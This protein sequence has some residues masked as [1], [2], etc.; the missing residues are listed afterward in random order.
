MLESY[1]VTGGGTFFSALVPVGFVWVV[2]NISAL[3]NA[4]ENA[5]MTGISFFKANDHTP[6][7]QVLQSQCR[8][9]GSWY[10]D[11]R[12]VVQA[13]DQVAVNILDSTPWAYQVTGYQLTLP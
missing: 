3:N 5:Q 11:G 7:F 2:R 13:G 10:Y 9:R 6:F 12:V 4:G 1:F 8:P